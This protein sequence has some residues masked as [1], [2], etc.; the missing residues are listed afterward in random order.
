MAVGA[1][2]LGRALSPS[3]DTDASSTGAVGD[4]ESF[5]R[6]ATI[7]RKANPFVGYSSG[8]SWPFQTMP[9]L[10]PPIGTTWAAL[11][12]WTGRGIF[13]MGASLLDASTLSTCEQPASAR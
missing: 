2:A 3:T 7:A 12:S 1:H 8:R 5:R 9:Y 4:A 11:L 13:V 10:P 6:R